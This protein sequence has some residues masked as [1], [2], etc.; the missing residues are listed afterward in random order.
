MTH[1]PKFD[2]PCAEH[3]IYASY[4]TEQPTFNGILEGMGIVSVP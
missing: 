1:I 2:K 4:I 3:P